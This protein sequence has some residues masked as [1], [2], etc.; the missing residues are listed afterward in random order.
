MYISVLSTNKLVHAMSQTTYMYR[1]AT[2]NI[3]DSHR[4][5]SL[6]TLDDNISVV[7]ML[8]YMASGIDIYS[9]FWISK[10]VILDIQNT[11]VG[12]PE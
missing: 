3:T 10:I 5:D 1:Y 2:H 9:F 8:K 12:Y 6:A 11:D 7:F 4:T